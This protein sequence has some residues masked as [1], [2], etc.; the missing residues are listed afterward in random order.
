M[1]AVV[2]IPRLMI[3][4]LIIMI[5]FFIFYSMILDISILDTLVSLSPPHQLKFHLTGLNK[6]CI[7]KISFQGTA[8]ICPFFQGVVQ[9]S[10]NVPNLSRGIILQESRQ[11][12]EGGKISTIRNSGK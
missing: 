2:I 8:F 9:N 3:H 11:G 1:Q 12:G 7:L 6:N 5:I 10:E 4:L